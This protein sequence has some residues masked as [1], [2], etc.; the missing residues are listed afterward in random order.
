MGGDFTTGAKRGKIKERISEMKKKL[1][2]GKNII[3]TVAAVLVAVV[4]IVIGVVVSHEAEI[5][6][7]YFVSDDTKLVMSLDRDIAAFEE[8]PYEP[9]LTHL[10]YYYTGDEVTSMRIYFAYDTV[11]EA[12]T[13]DANLNMKD[14]DFATTKRR[15]GRYIIFDVVRTRYDGLTVEQVRKNIEAMRAAGGLAK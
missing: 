1:E 12:E 13:A 7:D 11:A 15:N 4:A 2:Q 14:K 3:I 9:Q 8:G 6:D 10:V 5:T